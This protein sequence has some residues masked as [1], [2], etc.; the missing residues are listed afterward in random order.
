M[1]GISEDTDIS[2]SSSHWAPFALLFPSLSFHFSLSTNILILPFSC[3]PCLTSSLALLIPHR[4][5]LCLFAPAPHNK[6]MMDLIPPVTHTPWQP[7][8]IFFSLNFKLSPSVFLSSLLFYSPS[9]LYDEQKSMHTC[10]PPVPLIK[11]LVVMG[12]APGTGQQGP[13]SAGLF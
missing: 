1:A 6:T 5:W 7:V 4:V 12:A 9:L 2:L 13:A 10:L 8:C 3:A 11:S